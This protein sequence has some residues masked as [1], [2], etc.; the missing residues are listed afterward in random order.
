MAIIYVG[1]TSAGAANGTSWEN[2]YGSL[3]AAEDRPVAPGDTVYVAPGTYREMLTVDVTGESG[4]PI[5][6]IGDVCGAHTDGV[7]GVVRLTGSDNDLTNTRDRAV[8]CGAGDAKN[9]RTFRG[10]HFDL[11]GSAGIQSAAAQTGWVISDCS[12]QDTRI[13]QLVYPTG[14]LIE[15]CVTIGRLRWVPMMALYGDNALDDSG[16]V[17]R[18]C[19][20][21]GSN[22]GYGIDITKIGGITI[23][24]CGFIGVYGS[25]R[26][27]ADL[28]AGQVV[29]VNNCYF[30][31]ASTALTG[32]P[33]GGN[34]VEDYNAFWGC[35]TNRTNVSVGA[36]SNGYPP[37]FALPLL[38][39][40]GGV[41]LPPPA[42]GE[43][44]P[45]S[46]LRALAGTSM[47]A[48]DLWGFAR[49]T[50]DAKK[51][52]GPMQ[53]QPLA[54]DTGT[55]Y[56]LSPAALK[57]ADAGRRQFMI[58]TTGSEMTLWAR[59]YREA[60]YAGTNPQLIIRQPGQAPR[61][62]T[63]AG[64]AATWNLLTDTLTPAGDPDYIVV[65]VVSNN[66][67]TSGSYAVF[68]DALMAE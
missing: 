67:A 23:T 14:A 36:N 66:T 65:E 62:V 42:P 37:L 64:A 60:D 16:T 18:N 7:G 2:R 10:F 17:V 15:R 1:P 43:L 55:T 12:A 24:Q 26:L 6:Y 47:A 19:L 63:D 39:P 38:V 25:V 58:P 33:S 46:P 45:W 40:G 13:V 50:V 51:S 34:I 9:Y 54:R 31:W 30:A 52:W 20:F 27:T 49:P 5:A 22:D 3:N 53:Y 57:L 41:A 29:A 4:A 8:W 56:G 21:M 59:V 11:L 44:A 48:D 68:F 28:T 32:R 61:V 35:G